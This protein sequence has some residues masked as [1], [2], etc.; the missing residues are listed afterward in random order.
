MI[1]EVVGRVHLNPHP[2]CPPSTRW[3]R[4]PA[5][6]NPY[7]PWYLTMPP[8]RVPSTIAKG[9]IK[10]WIILSKLINQI[11]M[12]MFMCL[13]KPPKSMEFIV[14]SQKFPTFNGHW[15][16]QL[17]HGG[18]I[19]WITIPITFLMILLKKFCRYQFKQMN[20]FA[21]TKC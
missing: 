12:H 1:R 17:Q 14:N 13:S 15:R 20:K 21:W 2:S 18:T 4:I 7:F 6:L 19:L 5:S 16:I 8:M 11:Q 3:V 10:N 9:N